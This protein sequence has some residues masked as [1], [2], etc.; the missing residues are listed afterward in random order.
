MNKLFFVTTF[1]LAV[2]LSTWGTADV[3]NFTETFAPNDS[4]WRGPDSTGADILDFVTS[5]GPDGSSYVSFQSDFS[6]FP[7]GSGM[8]GGQPTPVFFRGQQSFGSSNGAFVGDWIEDRVTEF[9][10][11]FRHNLPVPVTVFSRFAPAAN[12]PGAV[13]ID[14]APVLP[15]QWT[16]VSIAIDENS[17]QFISFSGFDFESVFS[18]VANVQ[19]GVSVPPGFGGSPLNF[20][21]D[22]DNVQ[23]TTAAVP[24]PATGLLLGVLMTMTLRRKR[25]G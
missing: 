13:A 9:S 1:V 17:P 15:G 20:R 14:F 19:I 6:D 23:V 21:F 4:N 2:S 24:E 8:G 11:E 10:F 7:D 5:G 16:E 3:V 12:F 18:N 25:R 22:L